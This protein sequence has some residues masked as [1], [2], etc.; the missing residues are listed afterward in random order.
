ML[1]LGHERIS[2]HARPRPGARH[3]RFRPSLCR[4]GCCAALVARHSWRSG[5]HRTRK[6]DGRRRCGLP[7]VAPGRA[8]RRRKG[9]GGWRG[10]ARRG[11]SGDPAAGRRSAVQCRARCGLYVGGRPRTRCVDHGRPRSGCRCCRRGDHHSPSHPSC[12]KGHDRQPARHALRQGRGRIRRRTGH[13]IRAAGILRYRC[14]APV[15]GT[16]EG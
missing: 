9:A 5:H 8:R 13:R 7:R 4:A 1:S 6:H 15:A 10:S 12:P 3:C 16:D 11:G 2:D 14:A